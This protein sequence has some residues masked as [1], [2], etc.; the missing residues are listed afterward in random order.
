MEI[1]KLTMSY[2]LSGLRSE[3]AGVQRNFSQKILRG[4]KGLIPAFTFSSRLEIHHAKMEP[5]T[6]TPTESKSLFF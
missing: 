5:C 4:K 6:R 1:M 3:V 2:K